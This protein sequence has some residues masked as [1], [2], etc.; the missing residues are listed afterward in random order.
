MGLV[1][2]PIWVVD[3]YCKCRL[4]Y[5]T[6]MGHWFLQQISNRISDFRAE[7]YINQR[8]LSFFFSLLVAGQNQR[9][10]PPSEHPWTVP[11]FCGKRNFPLI[12][13]QTTTSWWFFTNPF[14]KYAQVK[15]DHFQGSGWQKL[16][17][18]CQSSPPHGPHVTPSI[19]PISR[20]NPKP[21]NNRSPGRP[22]VLDICLSHEKKNLHF[23]ILAV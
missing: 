4:I 3:I 18:W 17:G 20:V 22:K 8:L 5:Y 23:I 13:Q 12:K 19:H 11:P 6:W 9:R 16:K 21:T 2:L 1:Y 15:L 7:N 10:R 14:A